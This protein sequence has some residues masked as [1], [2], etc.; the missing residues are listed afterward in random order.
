MRWKLN[1]KSEEQDVFCLSLDSTLLVICFGFWCEGC[2]NFR[3][4]IYLFWLKLLDVVKF[5]IILEEE[6]QCLRLGC[7]LFV[8]YCP[9]VRIVIRKLSLSQ[10]LRVF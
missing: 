8:G 10:M 5:D 1:I 3:N 7:G 9:C 2:I 6:I 4:S